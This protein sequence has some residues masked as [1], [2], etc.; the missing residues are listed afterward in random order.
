M[1]SLVCLFW[2][3]FALRASERSLNHLWAYYLQHRGK[4]LAVYISSS[5]LE[6]GTIGGMIG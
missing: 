1:R 5:A 6:N 4:S 3:F 2:L